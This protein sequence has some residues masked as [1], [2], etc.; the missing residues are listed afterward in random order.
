MG[1][2]D[3]YGAI[4]PILKGE[5]SK[6]TVSQAHLQRA[7]R[8]GTCAYASLMAYL[9][10]VM[11]NRYGGTRLSLEI[12]TKAIHNYFRE[13]H[14]RLA[15][16]PKARKLLQKAA[17]AY[18]VASE[19]AYQEG[20]ITAEELQ[21]SAELAQHLDEAILEVRQ[22]AKKEAASAAP[23]V[24]ANARLD[25]PVA[26]EAVLVSPSVTAR[27][28]LIQKFNKPTVV[29]T[30]SIDELA[31]SSDLALCA[32]RLHLAND[33]EQVDS[34]I[35]AV[36]LL[37]VELSL[38]A[39]HAMWST[40]TS[41]NLEETL[42]NLVEIGRQYLRAHI[43]RGFLHTH[44]KAGVS[45]SEYLALIK[46]Q[47]VAESLVRH[48][49]PQ[50]GSTL[51]NLRP[52]ALNI[53][54]RPDRLGNAY[55]ATFDPVWD[56]QIRQLATFWDSE[57]KDFFGFYR[58]MAGHQSGHVKHVVEDHYD[59]SSNKKHINAWDADL[60]W[61]DVQW[62]TD[63]VQRKDVRSTIK[64]Q[65]PEMA[66]KSPT[67][68]AMMALSDAGH[69]DLLPAAFFALRDLA[70]YADY[71]TGGPISAESGVK[72]SD[73]DFVKG[74]EFHAQRKQVSEIY[75]EPIWKAHYQV[76]GGWSRKGGLWKE[77]PNLRNGIVKDT[78]DIWEPP[79]RFM[80]EKVLGGLLRGERRWILGPLQEYAA[81]PQ[82]VTGFADIRL[83]ALD[84]LLAENPLDSL[85]QHHALTSVPSLQAVEVLGT[86]LS[87]SHLLTSQEH[88]QTFLRLIFSPDLFAFLDKDPRRASE[89]AQ[90]AITLTIEQFCNY[91]DLGDA[92]TAFFFLEAARLFQDY[93]SFYEQS[94]GKDLELSYSN[95]RQEL[96]DI[97]KSSKER[98]N[99]FIKPTW[100][101]LEP[102]YTRIQASLHVRASLSFLKQLSALKREGARS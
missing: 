89:F 18:A 5:V 62:A 91:R 93:F 38:D 17:T 81:N 70:F 87:S 35:T 82:D 36:Q 32:Q 55:Y 39:T 29:P 49:Q 28:Q 27:D 14:T 63:W 46:L 99:T 94:A 59:G 61:G 1:P 2:S 42:A 13:H 97:I 4:L 30:T 3:L 78:R 12:Q 100:C 90:Q 34:V 25:K 79:Y 44:S 65:Y 74:L 37:A 98:K 41:D 95:L 26:L 51:P 16:D 15:K 43:M 83:K 69:K 84:E 7:Q 33:Q 40:V 45:I 76:F 75:S 96:R 48:K 22:T 64:K 71:L 67:Y 23:Q 60:H 88:R 21:L 57:A 92:P 77:I 6:A 53:W 73:F 101:L 20:E 86:Y 10:E 8:S 52:F 102:I 11:G 68:Q 54:I 80:Q 19:R 66:L 50:V 31:V 72:L 9:T 58:Y 24:V 85:R 47:A 56:D